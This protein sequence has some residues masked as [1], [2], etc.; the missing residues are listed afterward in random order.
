MGQLGPFIDITDSLNQ[1]SGNPYLKPEIIHSFE[2]GYNKTGKNYSLTTVAF[3]RYSKDVIR[4]YYDLKPGGV[5]LYMP[6]NFGSA[7]TFGL[8]NILFVRPLSFY[9]VT[10]SLSVFKLQFNGAGVERTEA[11]DA[12]CW[13]GKMVHNFKWNKS[14]FQLTGNYNSPVV[15]PQGKSTATYY[16]DF[17]YQQQLGKNTHLGIV[18]TDFF[19]ILE[20]GHELHTPAFFNKRTSKADTRAILLT[21]AYTFNSAFKEKLLENRFSREY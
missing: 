12:F 16:V 7:S 3:Y 10:I 17:G 2:L 21:F 6:K 4:A 18:A 8:D 13:Y 1:H 20:S 14:R 5:I 11:K 15:T 9:D 19:N